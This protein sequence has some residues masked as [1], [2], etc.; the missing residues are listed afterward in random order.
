MLVV[1]PEHDGLLI[2]VIG[3]AMLLLSLWCLEK[4]LRLV[5]GIRREHGLLSPFALRVVAVAF[6]LMPVN[7]F[8]G[9]YYKQHGLLAVEQ[10][11]AYVFI[12]AGLWEMA[13]RRGRARDSDRST[14]SPDASS[15]Q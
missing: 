6:L 7:G 8:F 9:D 14:L 1:A 15:R 10:A 3:A 5:V 4:A 12:S 2:K 11:V 13:R